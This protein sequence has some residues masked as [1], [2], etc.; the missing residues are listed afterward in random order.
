MSRKYERPGRREFLQKSLVFFPAA[1]TTLVGCDS[2]QSGQNE[3]ANRA[4]SAE[5]SPPAEMPNSQSS[6]DQ[7]YQPRFFS[8]EEWRFIHAAVARLIPSDERGPGAIEAGVPEFIDRQMQTPYGEGGIWYMQ[9]PFVPDASP[10]MGYQAKLVPQQIYRFGIKEVNDWTSKQ[11]DKAF[12]ELGSDEQHTVL[13]ALDNG[14]TQFES[15]PVRTFFNLLLQNTKEG[16]FSDPIHG[17]NR[18]LVG[19]KLVGFPGARADFMDWVERDEPYPFPPVSI[20]GQR[21]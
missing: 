12:H 15:V 2:R 7:D 16:F 6:A 21:G 18:N 14:E 8:A 11:Y 3:S 13:A 10:E 1:V 4:T 9:G 5:P 17:G 19:W 20:R